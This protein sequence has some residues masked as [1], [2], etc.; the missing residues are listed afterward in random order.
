MNVIYSIN[1][2]IG[3]EGGGVLAYHAVKSLIEHNSLKKCLCRD[4]LNIKIKTERIKKV[5]P[6]GNFI[7]IV[8]N[9]ISLYMF[10][11][12]PSNYINDFLFDLLSLKEIEEC[13]IFHSRN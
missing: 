3:R 4:Y 11:N 6:F 12:L 8:L 2:D 10:N 9:G 5:M 1:S 13:D 7:P